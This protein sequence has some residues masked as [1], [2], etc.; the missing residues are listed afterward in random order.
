M[1]PVFYPG[2]GAGQP[3]AETSERVSHSN[4]LLRYFSEVFVMTM[5]ADMIVG[6][7]EPQTSCL[8]I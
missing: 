3:K 2:S 6:V 8:E 7:A 1:L 4:S 5:K